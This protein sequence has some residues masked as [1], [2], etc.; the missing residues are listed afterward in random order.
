MKKQ[1]TLSFNYDA[2]GFGLLE[3]HNDSLTALS[4]P[5]RTGS[6]R[7]FIDGLGLINSIPSGIWILR[8]LPVDT[9]E[10]AMVMP[11]CG[12]GVKVRLYSPKGAYTHY[13]IHYDAGL[14]GTAGC[15][16]TQNEDLTI[17]LMERILQ[18]LKIQKEILVYINVP[19]PGSE[20]AKPEEAN[21]AEIVIPVKYNPMVTV[22]KAAIEAGA[23]SVI[24]AALTQ[25]F[26]LT[27]TPEQIAAVSLIPGIVAGAV[28]GIS[29]W[30]KK[31]N[32]GK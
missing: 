10:A 32:L 6:N 17:T 14:P 15:I 27:I 9:M 7:S 12:T 22:K 1:W 8:D 18:I 24:I 2:H 4:I 20:P 31:R 30:W 28:R 21:M 29:N 26:G 25:V 23:V 16:G 5:S 11:I 13:L 19:V 3:L